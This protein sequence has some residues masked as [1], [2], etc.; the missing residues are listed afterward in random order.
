VSQVV[1]TIEPWW[2][3]FQVSQTWEMWFQMAVAIARIIQ[4]AVVEECR[5]IFVHVFASREEIVQYFDKKGF[6]DIFSFDSL[7]LTGH[8]VWIQEERW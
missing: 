1:E 4:D 5:I 2:I 3:W 7:E 8:Q 6:L